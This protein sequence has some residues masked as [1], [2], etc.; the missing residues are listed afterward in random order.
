MNKGINCL[1]ITICLF[2][3]SGCNNNNGLNK[4]ITQE[5]SA[6]ELRVNLKNDKQFEGFYNWCREIG[7]W[8]VGDNMRSF[9]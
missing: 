6:E 9:F 8:I 4:P 3:F 7:D 5:L 2:F 1:I